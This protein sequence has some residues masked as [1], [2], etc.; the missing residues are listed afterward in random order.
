MSL[1]TWLGLGDPFIEER[2]VNNGGRIVTRIE[3]NS[4][5]IEEVITEANL[6]QLCE[7]DSRVLE[8]NRPALETDKRKIEV[9]KHEPNRKICNMAVGKN[10]ARSAIRRA[11]T[12]GGGQTAGKRPDR[13]H[14][15]AN[16]QKK[17]KTGLE[18]VPWV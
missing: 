16:Q 6:E 11:A 4:S 1:T 12:R 7:V 3:R 2:M 17:T 5:I 10:R 13:L 14:Q 8:A 15:P 18:S 9:N